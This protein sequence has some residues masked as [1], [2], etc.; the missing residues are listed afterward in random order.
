MLRRLY[1]ATAIAAVFGLIG[2]GTTLADGRCGGGPGVQVWENTYFS[3]GT[4]TICANASGN[5]SDSDLSNNTSGLGF[6][7]NW[8]NRISSYQTFNTPAGV[9]TCFFDG[10][11]YTGSWQRV[12]GN[13]N[14]TSP[15]TMNDRFSSLWRNSLSPACG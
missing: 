7:A 8:N 13:Y 3:G 1:R 4:W 11:G 2:T 6:F 12:A 9:I 15:G 14:M 10:T 5:F